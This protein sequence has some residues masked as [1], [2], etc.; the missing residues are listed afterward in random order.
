[1]EGEVARRFP[2]RRKAPL[3]DAGPRG[4]PFVTGLDPLLEVGVGD[5]RFRQVAAGADDA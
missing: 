3:A 2:V 4:D 5:D 1:M